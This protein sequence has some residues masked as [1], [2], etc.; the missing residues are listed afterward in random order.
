MKSL[1]TV[2][3]LLI[4]AHAHASRIG[5]A[6]I[7]RLLE[8]SDIVAVIT[9]VSGELISNE[10][11]DCGARYKARIDS[12]IKGELISQESY[13]EFGVSRYEIG[14]QYLAFLKEKRTEDYQ[15]RGNTRL[16]EKRRIE[17]L[18]KCN[19]AYPKYRVAHNSFG[20]FEL[21]IEYDP[22]F[23]GD[24]SGMSFTDRQE[25]GVYK[26]TFLI[27]PRFVYVPDKI[28]KYEVTTGTCFG[29][30]KGCIWV[31]M[32]DLFLSLG[33]TYEKFLSK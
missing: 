16:A 26:S 5:M 10:G 11:L 21:G 8:E 17:K 22:E 1:I 3:V 14:G 31:D 20:L 25:N 7:E 15:T 19:P 13:L 9:V 32:E 28:K 24:L 2:L 27:F 29:I 6:P 30:R 18:E 4:S 12:L 23:K 33:Y